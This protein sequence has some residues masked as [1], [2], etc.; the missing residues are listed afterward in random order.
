MFQKIFRYAFITFI[1]F[2][3]SF[4]GLFSIYSF[5]LP[6]WIVGNLLT[7][8]TWIFIFFISFFFAK[9]A[10][11][12]AMPTNRDLVILCVVWFSVT[13][14]LLLLYGLMFSLRGPAILFEWEV[15]VQLVLEAVAIVL[16][17][18]TSRRRMLKHEL[19]EGSA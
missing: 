17:G 8:I 12:P 1:K 6:K 2:S 14:T 5:I 16:A 18:F 13:M 4:F 11:H 19:G 7:V 9:W 3:L 10:L 15:L